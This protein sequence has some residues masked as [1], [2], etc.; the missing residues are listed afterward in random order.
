MHAQAQFWKGSSSHETAMPLSVA[1]LRYS[2]YRAHGVC[3]LQSSSFC[4][5]PKLN[6]YNIIIT[7]IN[8]SLQ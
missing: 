5:I 6:L 1:I 7:T 3:A 8:I 2:G 4:V